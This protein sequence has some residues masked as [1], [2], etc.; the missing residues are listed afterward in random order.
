MQDSFYFC[1]TPNGM[2]Q[3]CLK[4]YN[5]KGEE[6]SI[7]ADDSC[8][9]MKEL[10]RVDAMSWD[11]GGNEMKNYGAVVTADQFLRLFAKH[12]GYSLRKKTSK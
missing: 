12:M 5:Q 10:G 9:V 11:T 1:K 7:A 4:V 8:G 6:L 3:P 2:R